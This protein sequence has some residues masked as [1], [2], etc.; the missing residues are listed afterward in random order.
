[1]AGHFVL[2]SI[3]TTETPPRT[4]DN[5]IE[6]RSLFIVGLPAT[7]RVRC[8]SE[9]HYGRNAQSVPCGLPVFPADPLNSRASAHRCSETQRRPRASTAPRCRRL[10]VAVRIHRLCRAAGVAKHF[11]FLSPAI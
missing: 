4:Q 2:W 1:M 9:G 8:S 10:G 11:A 7:W 3:G 5:M 6:S